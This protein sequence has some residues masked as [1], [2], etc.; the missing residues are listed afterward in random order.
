MALSV[1]E[2]HFLIASFSS[3]IFSICG[4]S[5][6]PSASAELLVCKVLC[7]GTTSFASLPKFLQ[8]V[9]N[10]QHFVLH[11]QMALVLTRSLTKLSC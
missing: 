8:T 7:E 1:L 11:V 2:G 4:V 5:R 3:V 10:L 6:G 9:A